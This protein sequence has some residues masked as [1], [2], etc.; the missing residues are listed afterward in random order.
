MTANRIISRVSEPN[1]FSRGSEPQTSAR[2]AV[3]K[4]F[5]QPNTIGRSEARIDAREKLI[6]TAKYPSDDIPSDALHAIAV[7][8]DQPHARLIDIDLSAALATDGVVAVLGSADVPVNEYGIVVRDQPVL[9]GVEHTGRSKVL[10]NLS[11]WEADR[12]AVVVAETPEAARSGAAAIRSVWEPLPLLPD[13]DTALKS[14]YLLHP[15]NGQP[16]NVYRSLRIRKGD[17][18]KGWT[19]ADVVVESTYEF[20][21]QEHA[22]L[23]PEAGFAYI[24]S[25]NRV[26]VHVAGQW[27]HDDQSQIAHALDIPLEQVRVIYPAIGGAFG[28]REDISIQ[29]V[30]ALAAR[31]L[32]DRGIRRPVAMVWS[33]EESMVGHHKRHR[34]RITARWGAKSDG[35]ITAVRSEAWLDAGA[36]MSTSTS[37]MSN[38]HVHQVGPYIVPNAEVDSHLVYTS[39]IPAGAFRG[40]GAPQ[41]AF[42][43][44]SQINK[45]ADILG[46][47]P[48]D[49]RSINV[50]RENSIGVTQMPLPPSVTLPQVLDECAQ[51][52]RTASVDTAS[53]TVDTTSGDTASGDITASEPKVS[54][55]F[56]YGGENMYGSREN[57]CGGGSKSFSPFLSLPASRDVLRTGRGVACGFKN[58]GFAFGSKESCKA[59]IVLHEE[60]MQHEEEDIQYN[61]RNKCNG[62][63]ANACDTSD[64]D[65]HNTTEHLAH[66]GYR[67]TEHLACAITPRYASV[68]V[69]GADLGQGAHTAFL[70][71]TAEATGLPLNRV[72]CYFVDTAVV[73]DSGSASASRLTLMVGNAILGA[74]ERANIAWNSGSRPAV[75]EYRFVPPATTRPNKD[76]GKCIPTFSYGYVAQSVELTVDIETGHIQID[77][78]VSTHDV[79]RVINPQQ[80]IGQIEGAIVQAHGY[81]FTENFQC[82]Q[83][84]VLNTRFST[85]LMPGIQDIPSQVKSVILEIPDNLGPWG[86]KGVAE[87]GIIAYAPAV[88]AALHDA[89]GVWINSFPLT[90]DKV[91]SSLQGRF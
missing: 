40:F 90:P 46:I 28:G 47:D 61:R 22:Y 87:M 18:D 2:A 17:M 56:T 16:S 81:T 86:A 85:Y 12:L 6:G 59:K 32:A 54:V 75:G 38:C 71:M 19:D 58:I 65:V 9:V 78:V 7:F 14:S 27:A 35:R 64:T 79:G 70:Q 36:Y 11:R 26:A 41:A 37:V 88:T 50:L 63:Y 72:R 67:A 69:S 15:E 29:I 60:I 91:A 30:L 20:P 44:E 55:C 84:K 66:Y 10:C 31:V 24:D 83:G 25:E 49:I 53:T 23:Q 57:T 34:G 39:S 73:P 4:T 33:R 52:V 74:A 5:T 62:D 13:I 45:L 43:S 42:V 51:A 48:F 8:T 80:V 89:T 68:Y 3:P 21:Y 76:T 1:T 82:E 77:R